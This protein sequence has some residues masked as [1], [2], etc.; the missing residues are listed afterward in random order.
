MKF[1]STLALITLAIVA[2]AT[3]QETYTPKEEI[4]IG[5]IL[6][7]GEDCKTK[8]KT[9]S[10]EVINILL[11]DYDRWW[12]AKPEPERDEWLALYLKAVD[13][14]NLHQGVTFV[15]FMK[16]VMFQKLS[17]EDFKD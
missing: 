7:L 11:D 2:P 12:L 15:Q 17:L 6:I 9:P 16:V 5:T 10:G 3:A 1:I 4:P 13:T 14:G 8:G